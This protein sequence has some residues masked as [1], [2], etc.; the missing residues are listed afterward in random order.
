MKK[1]IGEWERWAGRVK[2]CHWRGGCCCC[3]RCCCCV[4]RPGISVVPSDTRLVQ[5]VNRAAQSV[6]QWRVA[7]ADGRIVKPNVTQQLSLS[8]S[9]LSLNLLQPTDD[10]VLVFSAFCV[11]WCFSLVVNI[12]VSSKVV[13]V[14]LCARAPIGDWQLVNPLVFV[15]SK[16]PLAVLSLAGYFLCAETRIIV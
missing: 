1:E 14:L 9:L 6:S 5:L 12:C 15:E 4:A 3:C 10:F 13:V 8:L 16:P 7:Q 2:V 11:C